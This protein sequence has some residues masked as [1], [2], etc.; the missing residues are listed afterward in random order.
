MT[1]TIKTDVLIIG[2][3]GA[4]ARAAMGAH[5][6]RTE[7]L[8]LTKGRFGKS[9][10]TIT[11]IADIDVDSRSARDLLGLEGDCADTKE[12][13]FEDILIEGKYL[14][15]QKLIELHVENDPA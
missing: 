2:S 5:D 13:F 1:G 11:G 12:I 15:N 10:A 9:G 8:L 4:G 7:V 6:S 14:N 3:E